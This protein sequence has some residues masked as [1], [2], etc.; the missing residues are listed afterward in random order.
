MRLACLRYLNVEYKICLRQNIY[1]KIANHLL[2][3]IY[4]FRKIDINILCNP[5]SIMSHTDRYRFQTNI[6]FL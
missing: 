1:Y 6:I 4:F 3:V 2:T 5:C